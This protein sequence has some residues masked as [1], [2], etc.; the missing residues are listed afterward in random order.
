MGD[1]HR[2]ALVH[3][4]FPESSLACTGISAALPSAQLALAREVAGVVGIPM[5]EVDTEV[6]GGRRNVIV[7][8]IGQLAR[9]SCSQLVSQP[10]GG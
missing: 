8:G 2:A 5:Y 6:R 1:E 7:R 9:P 10:A 4:V 3:R